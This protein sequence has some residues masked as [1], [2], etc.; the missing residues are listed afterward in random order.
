MTYYVVEVNNNERYKTQFCYL[1]QRLYTKQEITQ[2]EVTER[3][4]LEGTHLLSHYFEAHGLL[5]LDENGFTRSRGIL[6]IYPGDETAYFGF[7]ESDDELGACQCL[8]DRA[9]KLAKEKDCKKI[10]GPVDASF[11]IRYRFKSNH[12]E[13]SYTGE[14]YNKPYYTQ[15]WAQCGFQISE[16]YFSNRYQK[17]QKGYENEQFQK[18]LQ[19]KLSEGYEIK[20]PTKHIFDKTLVEVY[21]LLIELYRSFPA[22]KYVTREEFVQLYGYLKHILRYNMVKMAYD[23]GKAV[24]FFISI[25]NYKNVVYGRLSVID[26]VKIMNIRRKPKDYVMLYMGVDS[27]HK[28]LGK[29]MAE[30]IKEEL[31][32]VQTPSV[33]ALIRKGNINKDYFGELIEYEY[34]YD[35]L[36]KKITDYK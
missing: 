25:P 5:V 4:I 13:S 30:V 19:A 33:G 21:D 34:R 18:R 36:T 10:I 9:C 20:S 11:W 3:A 16:E 15:L 1:P 26:L 14:P 22:Y 23:H 24:G 7:F 32:V 31:Q 8:L 28:G 6:T 35:L 2:D 27:S 12:F 17:V 29:A